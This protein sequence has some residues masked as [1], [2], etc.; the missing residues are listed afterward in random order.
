MPT[1]MDAAAE[2]RLA[3]YFDRIGTVLGLKARRE[4]FAIYALGIFGNGERKSIEP[5]AARAC[6]DPDRTDAAHQRL[7]HFAA[8]SRWSDHHVRRSAAQY[9]L[10]EMTKKE[11]VD[12][13]I[14]DDTGFLKQGK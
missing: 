14:I 4:S 5:I 10:A 1:L 12:T 7:L 8:N 9:A 2:Q 3:K 13:W 6:T 11:T